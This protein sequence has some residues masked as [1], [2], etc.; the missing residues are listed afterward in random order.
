MDPRE[1]VTCQEPVC[2][3]AF[4]ST[5]LGDKCPRCQTSFLRI[6]DTIRST[7]SKECDRLEDIYKKLKAQLPLTHILLIN[8][9]RACLQHYLDTQNFPKALQISD[10]QVKAQLT[11]NSQP[12]PVLSIMMYTRYKLAAN[13]IQMLDMD[14]FLKWARECERQLFLTHGRDHAFLADV[15]DRILE[16]SQ[17]RRMMGY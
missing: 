10:E 11:L 9:R 2:R 1:Q 17:R 6:D 5:K 8:H 16:V 14:L 3:H 15:Q 4:L 13:C 12:H 7:L